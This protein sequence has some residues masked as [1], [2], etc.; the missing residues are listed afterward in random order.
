MAEFSGALEAVTGSFG[1]VEISDTLTMGGSGEI[2]NSVSDFL[3]DDDGIRIEASTSS[4][5]LQNPARSL[6]FGSGANAGRI[7]S[8]G[9]ILGNNDLVI[10]GADVL[11][12]DLPLTV[13]EPTRFQDYIDV[14]FLGSEPA[15][16]PQGR[17]RIYGFDDGVGANPDKLFVK[18][19]N[20]GKT[21]L[22]S[23]NI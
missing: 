2:T 23:T 8:D 5:G 7:W 3:I 10:D 6:R 12:L 19:S 22:A 14:P 20:G 13:A 16:P 17:I 15:S 11:I 18:F 4:G 9:F 21:I 1:K